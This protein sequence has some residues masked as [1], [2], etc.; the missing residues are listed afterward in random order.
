MHVSNHNSMFYRL[1]K[2]VHIDSKFLHRQTHLLNLE[3]QSSGFLVNLCI[4]PEYQRKV[5]QW[6]TAPTGFHMRGGQD[7]MVVVEHIRAYLQQHDPDY[8]K[9]LKE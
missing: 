5:K 7:A 4:D 1:L 2:N 3:V 9:I 8:Q 6:E